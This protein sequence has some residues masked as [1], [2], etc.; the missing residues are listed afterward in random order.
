M[1]E[2]NLKPFFTGDPR[3]RPKRKGCKHFSTMIK[4]MLET[5]T[6]IDSNPLNQS[7]MKTRLTAKQVIAY[8]L[9]SKAAKGD[10]KAAEMIID[11]LEGKPV[12]SINSDVNIRGINVKFND[13]T[14][15][16]M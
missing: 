2:Q 11:R 10:L 16:E 13:G 15:V 14:S 7:K 12:Q 6:L 4:E 1:N 9:I 3:I 5:K 8:Q